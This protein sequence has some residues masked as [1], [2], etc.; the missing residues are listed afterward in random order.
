MTSWFDV[1]LIRDHKIELLMFQLWEVYLGGITSLLN[2]I[3]HIK[4]GLEIWQTK[5]ESMSWLG[6]SVPMNS[7]CQEK[8]SIKTANT[9]PKIRNCYMDLEPR[10]FYKLTQNPVVIGPL[11]WAY[12]DKWKFK[13]LEPYI[14]KPCD[15]INSHSYKL[16]IIKFLSEF[17]GMRST[18]VSM[19]KIQTISM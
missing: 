4:I 11:H 14:C 9:M 17:L 7:H 19:N 6:V 1:E 5:E 12:G 18:W 16:C 10:Q 15:V 13:D 8:A 3:C 2:T